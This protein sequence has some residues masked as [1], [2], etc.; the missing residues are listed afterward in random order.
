MCSGNHSQDNL[1][2][3]PHL[4]RIQPG[5]HLGA[6]GSACTRCHSI[7]PAHRSPP[8]SHLGPSEAAIAEEACGLSRVHPALQMGFAVGTSCLT[9]SFVQGHLLCSAPAPPAA[10]GGGTG[11]PSLR[12]L[13]MLLLQ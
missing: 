11:D 2:L 8:R 3:E 5:G 13:A 7:S 9:K 10:M 6:L 4:L 12:V 1:F